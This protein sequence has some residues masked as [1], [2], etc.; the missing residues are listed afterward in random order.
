MLRTAACLQHH[1]LTEVSLPLLQLYF[2][3]CIRN[4]HKLLS[5]G[6]VNAHLLIHLV[7]ASFWGSFRGN[8]EHQTLPR[9]IQLVYRL[10]SEETEK[11][12]RGCFLSPLTKGAAEQLSF[13]FSAFKCKKNKKKQR[14]FNNPTD[15]TL[16]NIMNICSK[17]STEKVV[18][19]VFVCVSVVCIYIHIYIC[20]I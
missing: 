14:N 4:K 8:G 17:T 18:R 20:S 2:L 6:K 13:T 5:L 19:K 1:F 3:Q 16:R 7:Q 10:M 11:E 15:F 9:A 12:C